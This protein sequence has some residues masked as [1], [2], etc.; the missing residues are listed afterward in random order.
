MKLSHKS[1]AKELINGLKKHKPSL[2]R[3]ISATVLSIEKP[4]KKLKILFM[5]QDKNLKEF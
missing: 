4:T 1:E 3:K 5:N 2:V